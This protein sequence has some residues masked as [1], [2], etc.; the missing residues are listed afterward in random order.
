MK[1]SSIL[2]ALTTASVGLLTYG[3]LYE[4]NK[5]V[6]ERRR[7]RF[8]DWPK[9]LDGFR[10]AILADFHLRDIYSVELGKRAVAMALECEPDIVVI[11]GDIV[12]YWKPESEAMITE[13]FEPLLL[14][15]GNAIAVPGNHEYWS[16]NPSWLAPILDELSIK[17]LRNEVW[18][19]KGIQWAGIDSANAHQA[20]PFQTMS[21][22]DLDDDPIIALWHEPDLVEWL[23]EGASLQI[24]G[25]S[26]GGQ[27]RLPSG[28]APKYT[29][30][31]KKYPDGFYPDAPTPLF[32]SRGIGTTGPPSR[33]FCPPT[34]SVLELI[35]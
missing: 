35:C 4:S 18:R 33:L 31:G 6:L 5:L 8:K 10:I 13:V 21:L 26:H 20:D 11:P 2:F 7:L 25:H 14:M 16:G 28:W 32:V 17:L 9:R 24:S 30:N 12:G 3:A 22:T 19:H 1:L 29:V 15:N 34:V 27:F 23:P